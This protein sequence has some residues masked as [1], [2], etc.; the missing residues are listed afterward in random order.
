MLVIL[1]IVVIILIISRESFMLKPNNPLWLTGLEAVQ[2]RRMSPDIFPDH[3]LTPFAGAIGA[4]K[5]DAIDDCEAWMQK[6]AFDEEFLNTRSCAVSVASSHTPYS[7]PTDYEGALCETSCPERSVV[8]ATISGNLAPVCRDALYDNIG[9]NVTDSRIDESNRE[10][11]GIQG[12]N[13]KE[14]HA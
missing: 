1:I 13:Y 10:Y 3:H 4:G 14:Y 2:G 5:I 7:A 8:G 11:M 6:E 12:Y 9:W